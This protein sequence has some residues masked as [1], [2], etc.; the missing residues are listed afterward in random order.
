M[1]RITAITLAAILLNGC[2]TVRKHSP[3]VCEMW[4]HS[5]ACAAITIVKEA[6]NELHGFQLSKAFPT[7]LRILGERTAVDL[8][9]PG[10]IVRWW[11][12][13]QNEVFVVETDDGEQHRVSPPESSGAWCESWRGG[14][15]Y[16]GTQ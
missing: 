13:W 11:V 3:L 14:G 2:A 4:P 10:R 12:D 9:L 5:K 1:K 16:R 8:E 7:V 15:L 6:Q